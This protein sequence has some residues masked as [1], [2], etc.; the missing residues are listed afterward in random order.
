MSLP[1]DPGPTQQSGAPSPA[2]R[3]AGL[4]QVVRTFRSRL[5]EEVR[6]AQTAQAVNRLLGVLDA[7]RRDLPEELRGSPVIALSMPIDGELDVTSLAGALRSGGWTV[8]LPVVVDD[9]SMDF[10][11]W[12]G[13]EDLARGRYRVLEPLDG[14][15]LEPHIVVVPCVAVDQHG[16]RLGFGKGFYDRALASADRPVAIG[17]VFDEQVVAD[18]PREDWDVPLDVVVTPSTVIY[19]PS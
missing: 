6:E 2:Q 1:F 12:T 10:R 9:Q 18:V 4:R 8:T 17:A 7:A 14:Q 16:T 13:T 19:P 11:E 3:R 5:T 15:V